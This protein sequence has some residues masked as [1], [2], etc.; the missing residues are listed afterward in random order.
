MRLR[1]VAVRICFGRR[2]KR[3]IIIDKIFTLLYNFR[4]AF[5]VRRYLETSG[6]YESKFQ[7]LCLSCD[8]FTTGYLVMCLLFFVP[9]AASAPGI[10]VMWLMPAACLVPFVLLPLFYWLI[11]RS[12]TLLFGRYHF[13]LPVSAFVAALFFVMAWSADR[14]APSQ[15][16]LVFFGAL[17][18]TSA[19]TVYRYCAF[20]VRARLTGSGIV[21]TAPLYEMLCTLGA[22]AVI[23]TLAGFLSYDN[24]TAYINTSYVIG[25]VGVLLAFTQYLVTHYGIP[26]LGGVRKRSRPIKSVFGTFFGGLD[27]RMYFSALLFQSA[28]ASV[29]AV[30]VYF[31]FS[32]GAGVYETVICSAVLVFV[33]AIAACACTR[34][35]KRRTLMLSVTEFVCAA[36]A[37][38]IL[39]L[40]A[41]LHPSGNALLACLMIASAL[42]GIGGAVAVRQTKLRFL[43]VKPH[44][45][46]GTVYILLELTMLA[47]AAVA[48]TVAAASA[49][50]YTLTGGL[51]S[52][53]Y[54]FA[55]TA[56]FAAVALALAGH[57]K[58]ADPDEPENTAEITPVYK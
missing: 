26:R 30:T 31:G 15:I 16:C 43:S 3:L 57:G 40:A 42:T 22:G 18:F 45:T 4:I 8:A 44:I 11:H 2:A 51:V 1:Y 50:A 39:V 9:Y 56:L 46:V 47:S 19:V 27:K 55:A 21:S 37:C 58:S 36:L 10:T 33:Y 7:R 54:G 14:A 35:V 32:S 13:A 38:V 34:I 28:F 25:A 49:T 24:A 5:G 52:F 6:K 23:A 17:F 41:T 29:A 48:F 20:S 53:V 12:D